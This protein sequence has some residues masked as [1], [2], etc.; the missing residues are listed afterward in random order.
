MKLYCDFDRNW[1]NITTTSNEKYS[2]MADVQ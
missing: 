2:W 1:S